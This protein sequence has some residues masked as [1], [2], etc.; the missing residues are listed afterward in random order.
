MA[1][2]ASHAIQVRCP[3]CQAQFR[4]TPRRTAVPLTELPCPACHATIYVPPYPQP[5][6]SKASKT[7]NV[8]EPAPDAASET[9][10][11]PSSAGPPPQSEEQG[12]TRVR[13]GALFN[14]PETPHPE[15]A[16]AASATQSTPLQSRF[17][18]VAAT[19]ASPEHEA[20]PIANLGI[21]EQSRPTPPVT[22]LDPTHFPAPSPVAEP[23]RNP[24]RLP[25]TDKPDDVH[26]IA[27]VLL[28]Q[29]REK[30]PQAPV[31]SAG[32]PTS[33][34]PQAPSTTAALTS[35]APETE[36]TRLEPVETISPVEL[37]EIFDDLFSPA[38]EPE[39]PSG[40]AKPVIPRTP[41]PI[42]ELEPEP[43]LEP[44]P[45]PQPLVLIELPAPPAPPAPEPP[46]PPASK[47]PE[48]KPE[49]KDTEVTRPAPP[50]ALPAPETPE[51]KKPEPREP[52]VRENIRA[53]TLE[54]AANTETAKPPQPGPK[55]SAR[56]ALFAALLL[57]TATCSALAVH[58]HH[59]KTTT[60][61]APETSALVLPTESP[62][63]SNVDLSELR[64]LWSA[65]AVA[66]ETVTASTRQTARRQILGLIESE[67]PVR[68]RQLI[69]DQFQREGLT[70]ENQALFDMNLRADPRLRYN[71][72]TILPLDE[73]SQAEPDPDKERRQN[74]TSID[75]LRALG[76]GRSLSFRMMRNGQNLYAF[77]PDQR[78][79]EGGWRTEIAAY[80]LCF[81]MACHFNIPEN[82]PARVSR[83]DFEAL[84][85]R[86]TTEKQR[87]YAERFDDLIWARETEPDG[88]ETEYLYGTLKEWI[89]GYT[90]WPIEY[91][92]IW[93][94]W[95]DQAA[96][97]SLLDVPLDQAISSLQSRTNSPFYTGILREKA[98]ATTLSI[99]RQLSSLLVFDY[100]T[101]NHDR[102]SLVED[103]YGVNNHFAAGNFVSIDN[104][105]AFQYQAMQRVQTRFDQV[106]RFSRTTLDS[107]RL[108]RPEAVDEILFPDPTSAEKLR[109]ET[110]WQQRKR[111]LER[112]ASLS[113]THGPDQVLFF[114]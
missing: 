89:P 13:L 27:A 17:R 21:F 106:T 51:I 8:S 100:L 36:E 22:S 63:V 37:D 14:R 64:S 72:I 96:D 107:L 28:K 3:G 20:P 92:D 101:N 16:A 84:Y 24:R 66:S 88:T 47:K 104:G 83:A 54:P 95:L 61:P 80:N 60:A 55:S 25:E 69:L 32:A 45:T 109:L 112:V 7:S 26:P 97:P 42:A 87:N 105:A 93:R 33:V 67:D 110:F 98:D 81:I 94:P 35:S 57:A 43:A 113:R 41:A 9:R 53:E 77:K 75:E 65:I 2:H 99:A 68:A 62:A 1:E 73:G 12:W 86:T 102:F 71:V 38:D 40:F 4:L 39:I 29:L 30:R 11:A 31:S 56:I 52:E 50:P 49:T 111:L 23:A 90:L 44:E 114:E 103:Y 108:M 48:V 15:P 76:G 79:W 82:R 19:E 46:P 70:P 74:I 58:F 34:R 85:A 91:E 6:T 59:A 10:P 5:K 18:P 78:E